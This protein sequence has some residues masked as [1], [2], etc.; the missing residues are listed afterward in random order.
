MN[1][2]QAFVEL[3][4]EQYGAKL[5]GIKGNVTLTSYDGKYKIQRAIAEYLHFDER[6]QV[7]KEL[8]DDRYTPN[9]GNPDARIYRTKWVDC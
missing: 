5:G 6:L 4:A 7:A 9:S 2:V 8:I 3:S 1:D